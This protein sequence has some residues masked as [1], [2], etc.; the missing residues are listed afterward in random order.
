[1]RSSA[2]RPAPPGPPTATVPSAPGRTCSS[3]PSP[4]RITTSR[5]ISAPNCSAAAPVAS[6]SAI[7]IPF[8]KTRARRR[9]AASS[10]QAQ[11]ATIASPP[12]TAKASTSATDSSRARSYGGP[13]PGRPRIHVRSPSRHVGTSP[14]GGR[15]VS[16]PASSHAVPTSGWPASGSST[17]GVKI[18]SAPVTASSTNTVSE[19]PRSAAIAWRSAAGTAAPSSTT[20]SGLPPAPSE[21]TKTRRVWSVVVVMQARMPRESP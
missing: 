7:P 18:R 5:P 6:S 9:P 14:A 1:M 15:S 11:T 2:R 20:P 17:V 19:K 4:W 12:G 8:G 16:T 10:S 21:P 3:E 13:H